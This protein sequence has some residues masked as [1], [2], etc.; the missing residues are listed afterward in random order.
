M[1]PF[2]PEWQRRTTFESDVERRRSRTPEVTNTAGRAD[3]SSSPKG[4]QRDLC[5][6]LLRQSLRHFLYC[7]GEISKSHVRI[8]P[9]SPGGITSGSFAQRFESEPCSRWKSSTFP[10]QT[11]DRLTCRSED[12]PRL[13]REDSIP[14]GISGRLESPRPNQC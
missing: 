4:P 14:V 2:L 5:C 3:R 6:R 7:F 10:L 11:S 9:T 8:Y 12:E 13:S 1:N